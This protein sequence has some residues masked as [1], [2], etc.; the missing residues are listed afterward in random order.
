MDEFERSDSGFVMPAGS[1]RDGMGWSFLG[2]SLH[3]VMH[4]DVT[5]DPSFIIRLDHIRFYSSF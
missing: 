1:C 4:Y 3:R 2:F 5:K